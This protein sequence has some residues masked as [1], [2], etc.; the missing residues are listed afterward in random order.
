MCC[1]SCLPPSRFASWEKR[2][3]ATRLEPESPSK[4]PQAAKL[5]H[6][7]L[8]RGFLRHIRKKYF[9][10]WDPKNPLFKPPSIGL[11]ELLRRYPNCRS[12]TES[13]SRKKCLRHEWRHWL[14]L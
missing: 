3:I 7:E 4:Q 5:A 6:F 2:V 8:D 11:A 14:N 12:T 1:Q 10:A 13:G 9:L